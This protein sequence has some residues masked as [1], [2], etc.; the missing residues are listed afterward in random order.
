MQIELRDI[1]LQSEA[2]S[3]KINETRL[4]VSGKFFINEKIGI[5]GSSGSGKTTLLQIISGLI[6]PHSGSIFMNGSEVT[7]KNQRIRDYQ[8]LFGM[9][10]QFPEMQ[11]FEQSVGLDVGFG[12]QKSE[13]SPEEINKR[14][15]IALENVGLTPNRFY[16]KS[17]NELSQ[18][19][20]RRVAIAGVLVLNRSMLLFDEPTA[21]LD[22]RG[23]VKIKN[24]LKK[25]TKSAD[26]GLMI[27]SHDLE[28]LL[29]TV[30]KLWLMQNGT[31][32]RE[33]QCSHASFASLASFIELPRA[34]YL[35]Q[36][37]ASL[38]IHSAMRTIQ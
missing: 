9:C 22:A 32:V 35:Q 3:G 37:L 21:G 13:F 11:L 2:I 10:F 16:D 5:I 38:G 34:Y 25:Y 28:F 17:I 33:M 29:D 27:A 7:G 4:A 20:K 36:K 19:E 14:V 23:V 8:A 6:L 12:L 18:G 26:S 30:D 15:Q 24:L 31:I 1:C